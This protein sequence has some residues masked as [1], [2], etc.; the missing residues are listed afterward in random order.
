MKAKKDELRRKRG[1]LDL[2]SDLENV[3]GDGSVASKG[4]VKSKLHQNL[5]R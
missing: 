2:N 5:I 3:D 1:A 4:F